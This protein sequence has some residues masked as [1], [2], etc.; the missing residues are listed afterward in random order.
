MEL[1]LFEMVLVCVCHLRSDKNWTLR[2][3]LG[4]EVWVNRYML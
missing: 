2:Y 4:Y 3:G 1:A